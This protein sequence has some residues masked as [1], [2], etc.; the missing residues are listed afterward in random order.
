M[1]PPDGYTVVRGNKSSIK[2]VDATDHSNKCQGDILG[3]KEHTLVS[4]HVFT[5]ILVNKMWIYAYRYVYIM[6]NKLLQ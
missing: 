2:Y 4:Y 5:Y 3:R 6:S 1:L